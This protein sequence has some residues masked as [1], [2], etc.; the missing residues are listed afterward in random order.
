[1]KN[2]STYDPEKEW[3]RT[4]LRNRIEVTPVEA[5]VYFVLVAIG[6]GIVIWLD[7]PLWAAIGFLI[8]VSIQVT[9][10]KETEYLRQE[11][12]MLHQKIAQLKRE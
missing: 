7:I 3:A 11:I 8:L 10:T 9:Q 6:T 1:M 4:S 12:E 5:I 2:P